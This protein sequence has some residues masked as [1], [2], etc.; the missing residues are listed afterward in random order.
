MN[1]E[2]KNIINNTNNIEMPTTNDKPQTNPLDQTIETKIVTPTPVSATSVE[3]T[4]VTSSTPVASTPVEPTPVAPSTPVASTPVEPT[5]VAPSPI[6]APKK[7]VGS[8]VVGKPMSNIIKPIPVGDIQGSGPVTSVGGGTPPVDSKKKSNVISVIVLI[9]AVLILIGIVLFRYVFKGNINLSGELP[10]TVQE[11]E[12]VYKNAKKG[13]KIGFK[14]TDKLKLI[15]TV[16]EYEVQEGVGT[17]LTCSLK[18]ADGNE[19]ISLSNVWLEDD[20]SLRVSFN[21]IGDYAIITN[22]VINSELNVI[23][24]DGK[25]TKYNDMASYVNEEKGLIINYSSVSSDEIQIEASRKTGMGMISYGDLKTEIDYTN[26]QD[27]D[28]MMKM[29]RYAMGEGFSFCV[30]DTSKIPEGT[31]VTAMFTI[32][33]ADGILNLDKPEVTNKIDFKSYIDENKTYECEE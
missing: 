12:L 31:T 24:S 13:D 19:S 17:K 11:N 5:P 14:V 7:E 30:D 32:K 4:S 8:V 23:S 22:S 3:P 28:E 27:E 18:E 20:G 2:N 16:D 29:S 1:E 25:L 15:L 9:V 33:L 21:K 10:G 6:D 26:I